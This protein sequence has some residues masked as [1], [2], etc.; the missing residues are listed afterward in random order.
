MPRRQSWPS[1]QHHQGHGEQLAATRADSG[2]EP[3]L[4]QA[5]HTHLARSGGHC[6]GS[7]SLAAALGRPHAGCISV[8]MRTRPKPAQCIS[9]SSCIW[10][11]KT[12]QTKSPQ[13]FKKQL[14]DLPGLDNIPVSHQP[15]LSHRDNFSTPYHQVVQNPDIHKIQSML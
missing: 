7:A 14:H 13:R 4:A 15:P 5:Q 12:W 6:G 3:S 2:F 8:S 10:L 9:W 11:H 1:A